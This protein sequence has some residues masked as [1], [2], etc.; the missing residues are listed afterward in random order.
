MYNINL[1]K[2]ELIWTACFPIIPLP[3]TL[4][5]T[6]QNKKMKT[7]YIVAGLFVM[8]VQGSWQHAPQDTEENA[9]Y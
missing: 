3:P 9:R 5:S 6:R 4:C 1:I 7:I 8:L 2:I